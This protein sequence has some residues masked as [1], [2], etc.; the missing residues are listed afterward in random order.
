[1]TIID[2]NARLPARTGLRAAHD[3]LAVMDRLDIE[4]AIVAG[5]GY[6]S[7][8]QLSHHVVHGGGIDADIDHELLLDQ[9]ALAPERLLPVY[10]GNPY[11]GSE[12]YRDCGSDFHALKLAPVLH[13]V[14]LTDERVLSLIEVAEDFGHPV[15]LHCLHR[16]GFEVGELVALA[17]RFRN[18]GFVLEHAGVGNCDFHALAAIAPEPNIW[19]ETSG[20]FTL[21]VQAACERLGPERVIFG[22]EYPMHHP[23][24][25]LAKLHCLDLDEAARGRV[26]GHNLLGLITRDKPHA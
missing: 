25:E 14:P 4:K 13:G 12:R 23:Y 8:E 22:S 15:Y 11:R 2:G 6:I 17:R 21:V 5:G 10:I 16:S 7:P 1:M 9:C 20:G 19:F 26:L 3:L 24:A 18:L